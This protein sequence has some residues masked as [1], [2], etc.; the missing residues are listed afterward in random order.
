MN[1]Y[2]HVNALYP[3]TILRNVCNFIGVFFFSPN[4]LIIGISGRITK[5]NKK[6][7]PEPNR[8]G[9]SLKALSLHTAP[10]QWF[11]VL[12][13]WSSRNSSECMQRLCMK[14]A[15]L[16]WS[17][18]SFIKKKKINFLYYKISFNI[19]TSHLYYIFN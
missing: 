16:I 18:T 8:H 19:Y 11:P 12:G 1:S 4:I 7:V 6:Q 3:F 13:R 5:W 17:L 10:V 2:L 9:L 14:W 15:F